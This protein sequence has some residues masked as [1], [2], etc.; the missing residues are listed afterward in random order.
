ML[1]SKTL[2][3]RTSRRTFSGACKAGN[4]PRRTS[5]NEGKRRIG[6]IHIPARNMPHAFF[7]HAWLADGTRVAIARSNDRYICGHFDADE[8]PLCSAV[9]FDGGTAKDRAL[10]WLSRQRAING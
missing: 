3:Y 7:R 8:N 4:N 10:L 9:V 5:R 2:N 1:T 6:Q